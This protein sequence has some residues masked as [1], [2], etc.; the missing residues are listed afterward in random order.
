MKLCDFL[1][2]YNYH[3][4]RNGGSIS[5]VQSIRIPMYVMTPPEL[6]IYGDL[7]YNKPNLPDILH[8]KHDLELYFDTYI[9]F[10]TYVGGRLICA[11]ENIYHS[12]LDDVYIN[13]YFTECGIIS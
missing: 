13:G 11:I 8:V 5:V 2:N 1:A 10:G 7:F 4:H 6:Y 3:Y 12:I 9:K